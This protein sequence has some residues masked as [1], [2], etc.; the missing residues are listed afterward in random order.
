METR[1]IFSFTKSLHSKSAKLTYWNVVCWWLYRKR[2]FIAS[3]LCLKTI[4]LQIEDRKGMCGKR[5]KSS[6]CRGF[7]ITSGE[8]SVNIQQNLCR[9]RLGSRYYASASVWGPSYRASSWSLPWILIIPSTALLRS[10]PRKWVSADK[11]WKLVLYFKGDRMLTITAEEYIKLGTLLRPSSLRNRWNHDV[12][13]AIII[14]VVHK[15]FNICKTFLMIAYFNC[16]Y[17]SRRKEWDDQFLNRRVL[18]SMIQILTV[19]RTQ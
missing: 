16:F 6:A 5:R 7:L 13:N 11:A 15:G 10:S 12:N 14:Q 2:V 1:W 19:H 18:V 9:P 8:V 4:G 3:P 17:L